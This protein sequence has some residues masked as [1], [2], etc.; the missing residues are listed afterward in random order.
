LWHRLFSIHTL[1]AHMCPICVTGL[2]LL[3]AEY[4]CMYGPHVFTCGCTF[5][6]LLHVLY[7]EYLCNKHRNTNLFKFLFQFFEIQTQSRI[8]ASS[9]S[10][11][12]YFLR[13]L[14]IIFH[15]SYTILQSMKI[16]QVFQ[17]LHMLPALVILVL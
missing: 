6:L 10:S 1:F 5:R 2:P 11:T 3:K 17:F 13:N 9:S 7:C 4:Y 12:Y 14:C 16:I 8:T 15:H